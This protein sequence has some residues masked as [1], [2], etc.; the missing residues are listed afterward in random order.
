MRVVP[1]LLVCPLALHAAL[2]ILFEHP[3]LRAAYDF[4]LLREQAGENLGGLGQWWT[5]YQEADET[6]R[7]T[8][9][10]GLASSPVPRKRRRRKKRSEEHTSELQSRDNRVCRLRR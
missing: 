4:V 1:T 3:R 9:V 7:R 6:G 8:L 2:P 5:D 10:A